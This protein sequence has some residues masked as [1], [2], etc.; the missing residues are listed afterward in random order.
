MKYSGE[1]ATSTVRLCSRTKIFRA[2]APFSKML[3]DQVVNSV[4]SKNFHKLDIYQN[5]Y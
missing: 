5:K 1:N 3:Q 2:Q 4:N